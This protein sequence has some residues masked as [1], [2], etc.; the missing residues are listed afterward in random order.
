MRPDIQ[1]T[2]HMGVYG[3]YLRQFE[4]ELIDG[5]AIWHR[6]GFDEEELVLSELDK[7]VH[8][9]IQ[10]EDYWQ[11][12]VDRFV[13]VTRERREV[14]DPRLVSL[15][16]AYNQK[17]AR[18]IEDYIRRKH[19]HMKTLI[20]VSEDGENAGRN[21][22]EFKRGRH[23]ILITVNMAYVGYDYK[24]ISQI[25]PLT[26]YRSTAYLRQ[27]VARGL[28]VMPDIEFESQFCYVVAPNDPEMSKFVDVLRQESRQ[29]IR[30]RTDVIGREGVSRLN[31]MSPT[32][33]VEKAWVTNIEN[34]SLDPKGDL[35]GETREVIIQVLQEARLSAPPAAFYAAI[36]R[37]NEEQDRRQISPKQ[38]SAPQLTEREKENAARTVLQRLANQ[39]DFLIGAEPGRTNKDL[40]GI[41]RKPI[42]A[43]TLPEIEERISLVERWISEARQK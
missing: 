17:H 18:D 42:S 34:K 24:P 26:G 22:R 28:R 43:C 41:Y 37:F 3:G 36:Q 38:V 32:G 31:P 6:F 33:H 7:G 25:L 5:K 12:L 21:L 19:G 9:V 16:A 4:A 39:C 8:R 29:G 14:V 35:E 30:E 1:A 23:D 2:Y 15:I 13:D 10:H 11:P 40:F 27:L 20:A